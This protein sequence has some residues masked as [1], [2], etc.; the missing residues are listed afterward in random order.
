MKNTVKKIL[1]L[2]F[3]VVMV[4]SLAVPA[5]AADTEKITVNVT[6]IDENGAV[7]TAAVT[8]DKARATVKKA[9]DQAED[10]K[11]ADFTIKSGKITEVDDV[12]AGTKYFETDG[13]FVTVNDKPVSDDLSTISIAKDAKIIVYW[14]DAVLNT[15]LAKFDVSNINKGIVAFY[16]WDANGEKQPLVKAT[17]KIENVK[18][19]LDDSDE[20]VTDE[21]GQIWL[22]PEYLDKE[23]KTEYKVTSIKIDPAKSS[24]KTTHDDYPDEE[25]FFNQYGHLNLIDIEVVGKNITVKADIYETAGATG[26]MTMVYVL[27]AAAAVVTLAAV[28][29]MKKKSV[30]AN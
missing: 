29:V 12:K 19:V 16:Y 11:L 10:D 18:N 26:D 1:A 15:K 5:L 21:K 24:L 4:C 7:K 9:L 14:S 25:K 22:A 13:W 3:A 27:V 17:V 2:V 23:V 28:V 20:F 30:K 8:I 6:V